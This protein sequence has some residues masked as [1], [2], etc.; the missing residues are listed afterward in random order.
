MSGEQISNVTQTVHVTQDVD[1]GC[2]SLIQA[3]CEWEISTENYTRKGTQIHNMSDM[4]FPSER[5]SLVTWWI[6]LISAFIK[7]RRVQ[8]RSQGLSSSRPQD[9]RPWERV[10]EKFVCENR[11]WCFWRMPCLF[12]SAN[13]N[14]AFNTSLLYPISTEDLV[15]IK[16]I[17]KPFHLHLD[18]KMSCTTWCT[19]CKSKR[20]VTW[21][22]NTNNCMSVIISRELKIKPSLAAANA[23]TYN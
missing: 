23:S 12:C 22:P 7:E 2:Q 19:T 16:K 11:S 3:L 17:K 9:E 21:H 5:N 18:R 20:R 15:K 14:M 1:R 8:P 4:G 10:W 13:P 6:L